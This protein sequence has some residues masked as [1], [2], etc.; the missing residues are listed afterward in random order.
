[1]F[2]RDAEESNV[3]EFA[4]TISVAGGSGTAILM[5][6][7]FSEIGVVGRKMGRIIEQRRKRGTRL[8]LAFPSDSDGSNFFFSVN[9]RILRER[10]VR[11]EVAT[12]ELKTRL[13]NTLAVQLTQNPAR[14]PRGA[15]KTE[16]ARA[17]AD[18]AQ[19]PASPQNL[20]PR[21]PARNSM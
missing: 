20:Q 5:A 1:M 21:N 4:E 11:V 12:G 8:S 7:S 13:R 9:K 16:S 3:A 19:L 2:H 6:L 10:M 15:A 14:E 18:T 17:S